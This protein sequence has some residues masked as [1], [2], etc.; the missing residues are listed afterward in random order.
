VK[1]EQQPSFLEALALKEETD[2]SM[3]TCSLLPLPPRLLTIIFMD[4]R[5]GNF[6]CCLMASSLSCGYHKALGRWKFAMS[7]LQRVN[8]THF[9]RN[10]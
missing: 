10:Y 8:S 9:N 3:P 4:P 7:L 6:P 5:V 1:I 2:S